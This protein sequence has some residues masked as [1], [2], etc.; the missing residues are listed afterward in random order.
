[1]GAWC[2]SYRDRTYRGG[3]KVADP[4]VTVVC[5]FTRPTGSR[6]ALLNLDE[7]ETFFHEFGHAVHALMTD[8]P[9]QGLD[10]VEQDFVE[11]PSQIMEN[12]ATEPEMLRGY[13]LHYSTKV[14]IPENLIRK[15]VE[16]SHFNQGFTTTEL[17]AASFIDMDI[18]TQDPFNGVD[19]NEFESLVLNVRRGLIPEIAPRYRYPYFK[20]IFDSESYSAGYY[21]YIW[22]EVLDKD[23]YEAFVSSGDKFNKTVAARFREYILNKGGI[24]DGMTMYR[25]FRGGDPSGDYL[26]Y[27]RG[28]KERPGGD[29]NYD[30]L[31]LPEDEVPPMDH[32][33]LFGPGSPRAQTT[34]TDS[35]PA[36]G[37]GTTEEVA[38]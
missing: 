14:P 25:N 8:V 29:G 6:P 12:W 16:S 31:P 22:A 26:L 27:A 11:L 10:G 35:I 2:G 9:Y 7:T 13:A 28:L 36:G 5:N 20:H 23:A 18:H 33:E 37:E 1:M 19:V 21:S 30:L 3:E 4:I 15:I 24:Q 32:A 38:E 17:L 34:A